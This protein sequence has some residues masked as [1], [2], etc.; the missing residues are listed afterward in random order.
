[1][2]DVLLLLDQVDVPGEELTR[3]DR[4]LDRIRVLG[5]AIADHLDAAGEVGAHAVHLI[6]EDH[7]RDLVAVRLTPDGLR[8]RLDAGHGVQERN[9]AIE[10]AKRALD[11]NGEV[12]VPRGVDDVDAVLRPFALLIALAVTAPEARGRGRGDRD[13]ALLL[14]LH[15]VHGGRAI[16]DFADLVALAG[17]VQDTLG[18]RRLPGIDVGHDADIAIEVERS[19]TRHGLF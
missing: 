3:A 4:E 5:Q 11:F 6:G 18:R 8:L 15:P 12:D 9:G 19:R 7:A 14:L 2:E 17:I 16:V 1:M 13:A 10:H